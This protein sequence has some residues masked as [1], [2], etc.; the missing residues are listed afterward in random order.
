[1]RSKHDPHARLRALRAEVDPD[2]GA[3]P[4]IFFQRDE[5]PKK[6]NH[7]SVQLC[8]Q[9]AETLDRVL[10]D[11]CGDPVLAGLRVVEVQPAPDASRLLVIVA[12]A[13]AGEP[14]A[15]AAVLE[16]LARA[17]GM[18]RS[19]AAAAITRRRAPK[20]TFRFISATRDR[21]EAP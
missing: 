7:K 6:H 19:C 21:S 17:S 12:P 1:M 2:D 9:V 20:L 13:I 11:E 5:T 14:I 4:K 3:D 10:R 18:L 16:R 15:E 8:A